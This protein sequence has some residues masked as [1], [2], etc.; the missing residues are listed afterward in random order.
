MNVPQELPRSRCARNGAIG[1]VVGW[2]C[3]KNPFY[4]ISAL[5][6]MAGLRASF[7]PSAQVFHTGPLLLGLAG[8]TV[9]LAAAGCHLIRFGN[10]WNDVRTILL[11]IVLMLLASSVIADEVLARQRV[12]GIACDAAG[13]AFAM[14]ISEAVLRGARLRLPLGFRLP[15]YLFLA[16]FFLYPVALT[17]LLAHPADPT[18]QWALFGFAPAAALVSLT[19][20]PAVRRGPEYVRSNGSPWVWPLYPWTLFAFLGIGVCARAAYLCLSVHY[21]ARGGFY[22]AE[23]GTI[24]SPYFLV[25]FL[26]A[27]DVLL[28]EIGLVGRHRGVIRL[29]LAVPVGL[30]LMTLVGNRP[31]AVYEQFLQRFMTTLGGSPLYLTLV[32]AAAFYGFA[33]ARRV[34]AAWDGLTVVLVLLAIVDGHARGLLELVRPRILPLGAIA[35][36]QLMLAAHGGRSGRA[37]V[38]IAGLLGTIAFGM[39]Q[40]W[41]GPERILI[42]YHLGAFGVLAIGACC[43][44]A[45]GR[46]ARVSGAGL[47]LAGAVMMRAIEPASLTSVSA[48]WL[49]VYPLLPIGVAV[50]YGC[51]TGC[52][53]YFLAA[54]TAATTWLGIA[55]WSAY[56]SLRRVLAGLD[57]IA[58]GLA[59]FGLALLISLRKAGALPRIRIR[60]WQKVPPYHVER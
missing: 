2:I 29:A 54:L 47:L 26:L 36:V 1:G 60:R 11:L 57:E 30:M 20:L 31:E 13:L 51:A 23:L 40:N 19:L 48:D 5:L 16:L 24:F 8:Y 7:D 50:V 44:D 53:L 56:Q 9:L 42:V 49:R 43:D 33:A 3:T 38:G 35:V 46:A 17:R 32:T 37:V 27:V 22:T 15:Y 10:V 55:A 12:L 18:L 52:R 45:L 28:L 6:V 34:S 4:V 41:P 14:I 21:S 58:F 39:P 59:F 25:P